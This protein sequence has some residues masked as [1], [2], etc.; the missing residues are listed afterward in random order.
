MTRNK[1][2][3]NLHRALVLALHDKWP[4]A[5]FSYEGRID[6][7]GDIVMWQ[8]RSD[9]ARIPQKIEVVADKGLV[10]NGLTLEQVVDKVVAM[11]GSKPMFLATA[12]RDFAVGCEEPCRVFLFGVMYELPTVKSPECQACHSNLTFCMGD[13]AQICLA[14]GCRSANIDVGF[15]KEVTA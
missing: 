15:I 1:E 6:R 9:V 14:C 4:D 3:S 2:T 5:D 12:V 10:V 13:D 8:P 7:M 11:V